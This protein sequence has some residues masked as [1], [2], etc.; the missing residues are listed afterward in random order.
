M[1]QRVH[2][3][4][5][6]VLMIYFLIPSSTQSQSIGGGIVGRV[7][8]QRGDSVPAALVQLVNTSTGQIRA[9]STDNEGR[10]EAREVSPGIY[11]LTVL[12]GGFNTAK[13]SDVRLSVTQV[14]HVAEITLTVAPVGNETIEVRAAEIAMIETNSPALST[15]FSQKQIRELP[16]LTRDINNLALL[17]PG[18]FS[19]RTFSFASTL[20]P[21]AVNGS[22]GRENSFIIDSV[23]NNEP[24]FGG[25]AA[26][27]TNTDLFA[28]YRVITNQYK[29][30]FG[31]N[32]GSVVNLITERGGNQWHGSAFWFAQRDPLNATNRVERAAGLDRPA[33]F[34]ENVLGA[35]LG[36]PVKPESTWV[37]LTYQWDGARND[38]SPLYPQV[39]TLPTVRGLNA[40]SRQ[41][42]TQT[43]SALLNDPTVSRLPLG[44]APC[45]SFFAGLPANNPCTIS[46]PPNN[47]ITVEGTPIEF[48]SFLVPRAG[49]FDVRDHQT[50]FRVDHRLTEK[51]D[52]YGRYLFDDLRT[53][54]TVGAAPLEV[55]FFDPGLMPS[56]HELFLQRTQNAGLFWT[57][58]WPRAL[59]ELR[60]SYTRISSQLGALGVS[61][62]AQETLPSV[63]VSDTFATSPAP[64]GTPAGT[65][66]FLAAFPGAG[67]VFTMGR[68]TRP[69]RINSN[70]YQVQENISISRGRHSIKF[71]ANLVRT[72]SNIRD[73]PSNLG[74][75]FFAASASSGFQNFA[76]NAPTFAL[77]RFGNFGGRGG[78]ELPLRQ[79]S[80]FYFFEDDIRIA[81]SFTLNLGLRYENYGQP[82]NHIAELNPNFGSQIQRDNKDFGPRVGFALGL[83]SRTVVRGGY[84]IY[85]NPT[86][87]N[88]AL[89]AWQSGPISPFVVGTPSNVY[90]LPPFNPSDV[91]QHLA[92]CDSLNP[93]ATGPTFLDCTSQDSIA[94]NLAQP[95]TQSFSFG[96]QRQLGTDL[97]LEAAYVGSIGE[98]LFQRV[99]SNPRG[100][101]QIQSPCGTP[102]CATPLPRLNPN[103]GEITTIT[104]GSRSNYHSLQ[105]SA[106]KR[107]SHAGFINGLALTAA[108]TFSHLID[109]ASEIFGPDVRRVRDFRFLRQNAEP[110]EVITPFPQNP[111][112][113]RRAE[114]GNSSFHR[115]H[116]VAV[117]FLWALPSPSSQIGR[118]A[119][120]GWELS[121]IFTAQSG[122]PFNPLNSFGACTDAGGDGVLTNDRP[123][124]GDPKAPLNRVALV[125]DP[126]CVS[127]APGPQSPTGYLD[128]SGSPINPATAHFVQVPL[129]VKPGTTFRV[130]SASFVA[131]SAGR[132]ILT[133]PR[134]ANFD[135]AVIKSLK[136]RDRLTFQFRFEGY[137]LLNRQNAGSAIGNVFST[138]AQAVPAIA[139]GS[140]AP[141]VTPARVSGVI[142]ENSLDATDPATGKSL[143]LSRRFMNTSSRRVQGSLKVLF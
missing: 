51:D 30:E 109:N 12:K 123:S 91:V 14:V 44:T 15:A 19:V 118:A 139:F 134:V 7:K 58:A 108:Y 111:N 129:G 40:L 11:N 80:Q 52:L 70:L 102:P 121:G 106:T 25:A 1:P 90:P 110:I 65:S 46:G 87:F 66:A 78:E 85:Y 117:S 77:Q 8:D 105:L 2:R 96:L 61:G 126:A 54:R 48:G 84:G 17:A 24:L 53:P 137:D 9:V 107:F 41:P 75:Y 26:Q 92:D 55:G 6:A 99:Q 37:F 28:E 97:L 68:D 114:R 49:I 120:G 31:R 18:V 62:T 74:E 36:G 83:G 124:I 67:N 79:F 135:L 63:T 16:L 10:Y 94:R 98:R 22:R 71:G 45:F 42:L 130:G 116:R 3:F 35:S 141:S 76:S 128:S 72:L 122:Q 47:G 56:Y 143:F 69:S 86:A 93:A 133:G 5:F 20:V 136:I 33:P 119:L 103:R 131:G 38:L 34:A 57:H 115:R 23:D 39:A 95:R 88:I 138:E 82:I 100:G 21:F 127:I 43:L 104:N 73:I 112:D 27:F 50:S 113:T 81:G 89:V 60:G 140:V 142:P 4:L 32:S 59:H 132:N 125:A 29:A 64:G 13:V 101:W